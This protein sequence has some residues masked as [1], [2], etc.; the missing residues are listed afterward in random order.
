MATASLPLMSTSNDDVISDVN[1]EKLV[2]IFC[3]RDP[4]EKYYH[5][6]LE[7][8]R[9]TAVALKSHGLQTVCIF[10][11][12]RFAKYLRRRRKP[13]ESNSTMENDF[14]DI[15]KTFISLRIFS[16]IEEKSIRAMD[17]LRV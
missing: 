17:I 2:A 5:H 8:I 1:L 13:V 16:V 3:R 15:A 11:L 7:Y 4:R 9:D 14:R 6:N 10:F 12:I